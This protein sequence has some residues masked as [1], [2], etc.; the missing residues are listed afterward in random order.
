MSWWENPGKKGG[1][2]TE[3]PV[4]T[5]YNIEFAFLVDLDNDGKAH[6]VIPQ[7]GNANAPLTWYEAKDGKMIA[8]VISN[9]SYGHGIGV[10]DVN[11]D[12]RNDILTHQGWF[13]APPD[14]RTGEWKFHPDWSEKLGLGFMHVLDVDGD[15]RNDSGKTA[16]H[17]CRILRPEQGRD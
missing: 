1:E 4:E 3:H 11:G 5:K 10:G 16:P 15:G 17:D 12:G 2:W 8:Q 7:F 14:P 6:E 9:K 13:E